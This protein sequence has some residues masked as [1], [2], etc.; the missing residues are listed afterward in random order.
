MCLLSDVRICNTEHGKAND[1]GCLDGIEPA[2]CGPH[3]EFT[4]HAQFG[5][6][7][8]AKIHQIKPDL[9]SQ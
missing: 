6:K 3:N 4:H 2:K 8:Q 5:T 1:A 9:K 7:V